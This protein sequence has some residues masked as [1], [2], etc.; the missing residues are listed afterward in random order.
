MRFLYLIL[1][2]VFALA[3]APE[4]FAASSYYKV[5]SDLYKEGNYGAAASF[6]EKAAKRNGPEKA[7][8]YYLLGNCYMQL[9]RPEDAINSYRE[10][11]RLDSKGPQAGHCLK[12]LKVLYA[13]KNKQSGGDNSQLPVQDDQGQAEPAQ[14]LTK[15]QVHENT[16]NQL[17]K[18]AYALEQQ[19]KYSQSERLYLKGLY[20]AEKLGSRSE[21]LLNALDALAGFYNAQRKYVKAA[22]I[23]SRL[24]KVT[25]SL[26]GKNSIDALN[27]ARAE[28]QAHQNANDFLSA[29]AKFLECI[30]GWEVLHQRY[31]RSHQK[32]Y[33][34][35]RNGLVNAYNDMGN[36]YNQFGN[37]V[38]ANRY[39]NLAQNLGQ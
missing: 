23:Y 26:R 36:L 1:V 37:N 35:A 32:K 25:I 29:Q 17:L 28:G 21:V 13:N 27:V 10:S 6:F 3:C 31:Q 11:Y 38:Q 30:S 19:G 4:C 5:G 33:Q 7:K 20:A 12:A 18:Q 8:A 34:G 15:S 39:F 22:K 9:K 2:V 24:L 16:A 14:A